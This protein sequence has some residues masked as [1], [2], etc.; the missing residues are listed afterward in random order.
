MNKTVRKILLNAIVA[1]MCAGSVAYGQG[2]DTKDEA[3]GHYLKGN[4]LYQEGKYKEAEGEFQKSLDLLSEK[5]EV[6][7]PAAVPQPPP[8]K[9][10]G[11]LA[12]VIGEEDVLQV[13]V[14]QNQDLSQE[15]IVRPD[16][17]ISFPLIG[18]LQAAGL[19]IPQLD[20]QITEKLKEYV[21]N[22]EVSIS[23]RKM[24][25]KKVI[26]LGEV[27]TPG[28]YSVTGAQT[29]LEAIGLAGGFTKD[30]V[31]SS[32]VLIRGGFENPQAKRINLSRA[33][34]AGEIRQNVSLQA[35]DIIFVPKKFIANLNYF[36]SQILD[37]ISKG[38]YTA[39]QLHGF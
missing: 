30:S 11:K 12:Y 37:P 4:I 1:A 34:D 9:R 35:E 32:T 25:G 29:I 8:P 15:V 39:E 23:I 38:V 7:L 16:G 5:E 17:M 28:V 10:G 26:V 27:T 6:P 24:G 36:L 22:P 20:D 21:K 2:N 14:W 19:T 33:L 13:S 31:P 3:R 18:D